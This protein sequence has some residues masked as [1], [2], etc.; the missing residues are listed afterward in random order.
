MWYVYILIDTRN[1]Q[2]F[3]VGKGNKRRLK[4]T[5][6]INSG[7]NPLKKKFLKELKQ[8]G[9]EPELKIVGEHIKEND[10]LSQEKQLI[11]EYG[12]IIK[13]TGILTN[14]ADGG[15][16]GSTGHR[17]SDETKKLWS[18][19]RTGVKQ[20]IEHINNR[21]I[22][23]KGKVRSAESKR[24][25]ILA[26]IRRTNPE[27]KVEIILELE[28]SAYTH[29]MYSE[30]AKKLKCHH[31]LISRIHNEIELYKEALNDWIKK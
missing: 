4:A 6:N 16:Q 29:G 5:S 19:Q 8:V 11:E 24:K 26:S 2:P 30:I 3:Y 20:S 21:A 14:F 25:Y 18:S 15:E 7:S 23:L 1:N 9:L 13:G 27:L 28:K 10:A 31:E 12:R 17:F 22:Q